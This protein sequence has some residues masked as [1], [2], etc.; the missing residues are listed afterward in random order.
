M[1][2]ENDKKNESTDKHTSFSEIQEGSQRILRKLIDV[3][4]TLPKKQKKLCDFLLDNYQSIGILTLADLAKNSGVG[5]TTVLR[6]IQNIG[7]DSYSDI[8]KEIRIESVATPSAWWYLQ[9]SFT[10]IEDNK[11][12]LS[13]VG[14]ESVEALKKTVTSS[15]QKD[16]DKA[17]ELLLQC[18]KVYILGLRSSKGLGLYFGHLLEEFFP[19][20]V[21]LGHD[22]EFVFDRIVR[23]TKKEALILIDNAP[24]TTIGLETAKLCHERGI[25]IILITDHLSSPAASFSNITLKTQASQKQYTV[26]PTIYLLESIVVELGRKTSNESVANLR[27]ISEILEAKNITQPFTFYPSE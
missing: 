6:L 26:V 11:H 22:I 8:K 13:Q 20:V 17:I 7:Y 12:C 16:F 18:E 21:Q 15:L 9:K 25:H 3:R 10:N 27:E 2:K 23:A 24:F 1:G 19:K 5:T 4:H 14:E